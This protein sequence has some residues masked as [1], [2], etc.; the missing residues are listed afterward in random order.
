MENLL[1]DPDAGA[2]QRRYVSE[3]KEMIWDSR[4]KP[5]V[6]VPTRTLALPPFGSGPGKKDVEST[7]ELHDPVP[8]PKL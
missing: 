3:P 4:L 2:V 1:M 6:P 5:P 8:D 7:P